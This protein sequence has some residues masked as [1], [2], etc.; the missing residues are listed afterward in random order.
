MALFYP[1]KQL[2]K[3]KS[4]AT[5]TL[6]S[7]SQRLKNWGI[8][9]AIRFK[10]HFGESAII[11]KLNQTATICRI[12]ETKKANYSRKNNKSNKRRVKT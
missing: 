9:S 8:F 10:N 5:K 2:A 3:S 4:M 11:P 7:A 1:L 12:P 6:S